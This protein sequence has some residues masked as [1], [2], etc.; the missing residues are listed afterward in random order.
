MYHSKPYILLSKTYIIRYGIWILVHFCESLINYMITTK[1]YVIVMHHIIWKLKV[2]WNTIIK[3]S[4]VFWPFRISA[5]DK[6]WLFLIQDFHKLTLLSELLSM[7]KYKSHF[8][9][10]VYLQWSSLSFEFS[11]SL[12]NSTCFDINLTWMVA[13]IHH[14]LLD[15]LDF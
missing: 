9:V 3:Q 8:I 15:N 2:I 7:T 14:L 6:F 1:N 4:I 11:L 12:L 13:L 10:K 5:H